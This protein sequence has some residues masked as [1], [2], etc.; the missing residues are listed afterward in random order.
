MTHFIQ[1]YDSNNKKYQEEISNIYL[2]GVKQ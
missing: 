1:K 2:Y